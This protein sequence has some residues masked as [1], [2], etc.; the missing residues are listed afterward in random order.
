MSARSHTSQRLLPQVL[1]RV[2]PLAVLALIGTWYAT[3]RVVYSSVQTELVEKL[4]RE[5]DYEA[6]LIG[7]RLDTLL[8]A[9]R[10]IASNDLVVNSLIDTVS[11]D[12]YIPTFMQS[13]RLPGPKAAKVSF[14]DYRGRLIASNSNDIR[15]AD[16]FLT[17]SSVSG[18]YMRLDD[19]GATFAVPVLYGGRQ[20]GAIVVKYGRLQF[21]QMIAIASLMSVSAI[22]HGDT[23]LYASDWTVSLSDVRSED[24]DRSGWI[25]K[26]AP[27][28]G[29][30]ALKVT[31]AEP[32]ARAF[33]TAHRIENFMAIA[34]VA[35]LA[36]LVLGIVFTA[37]LAT[38][39]LHAFAQEIKAIG[40]AQDLGHRV[41]TAGIA[42]FDRLSDTFNAMLQR[43]QAVLVSHDQL[44]REN[45]ARKKVE[46]ELRRSERRYRD[47]VEG[48]ARGIII[49]SG[50]EVLFA[51]PAFA[52]MFGF[53][54]PSD[55]VANGRMS[56][57]FDEAFCSALEGQRG[58]SPDGEGSSVRHEIC[59]N[60]DCDNEIWFESVSRPVIWQDQ[61]AVEASVIDITERKKVEKLKS[62]FV[63]VVSHELRTPLTSV[64]G[65]LALIR[66]GALGALPGKVEP[67]IKIAHAN[68]E[69]L[70]AL[71]NNILDVEKI[72]AGHMDFH[73]ETV[74][75][76]DLCA[77][78]LSENVFY[79]AKFG[80]EFE[81]QP[82]V[83][84][85]FV[86]ADRDRLM[87]VLANLLSN[88][89]KFSP[90]G[91]RVVLKLSEVAG[92]IRFS[93]VDKGAGIPASKLG[94]IFEKFKQADSS[95][96]RAKAGTGL[97]LS[98][99]QS[100]AE[101]HGTRIEVQSVDGE[102]STFYFELARVAEPS[103]VLAAAAG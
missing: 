2:L 91:S 61:N 78:A 73:M 93:V 4:Q 84:Q 40:D 99:C 10:A 49:C 58:A 44:D 34:I 50:D 98:I 17:Q 48:S 76:V 56:R 18:F 54:S 15:Q 69:R 35:A 63:S 100:I 29:Y 9:M 45:Q 97:G 67:L 5:A 74:D 27:V 103:A 96:S 85:A 38:R 12:A 25:A 14:T 47:M 32:T 83:S 89:A 7:N 64:S 53:E 1:L 51:N 21:Q 36:A 43:M 95:D 62:E 19:T 16:Y 3:S 37:Y 41:K 20:E 80:V 13:L 87:Q 88:A 72:E 102:G 24:P 86:S 8:S 6:S 66:S 94:T 70:A 28:P 11:R 39:P 22:F 57:L 33:A 55:A 92:R 42:E 90:K 75:A 31:V 82:E 101:N 81:L 71:V 46:R 79:G 77:Q 26:S 52:A 60:E 30:S 59:L 65:S 68:T 23:V